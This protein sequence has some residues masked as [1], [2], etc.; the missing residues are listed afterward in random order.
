M[1]TTS[2]IFLNRIK[3]ELANLENDPPPGITC[4]PID[5][6]ITHLECYLQGP[7]QTPYENGIF[8]LDIKMPNNYPFDPPQIRFITPIYHP[9]I[10]EGGRICASILKKTDDG[11]K[12]SMN[13]ST[14]LISLHNLISSPNPDDP[15]DAEIANEYKMDYN[16][17]LRKAKDH[18]LKYAIEDSQNKT[19]SS[20]ELSINM[21]STSTTTSNN[22]CLDNER[23]LNQFSSHNKKSTNVIDNDLPFSTAVQNNKKAKLSLSRNKSNSQQT[24]S[25]PSSSQDSLINK[26][27]LLSTKK[28]KTFITPPTAFNENE[29]NAIPSSQENRSLTSTTCTNNNGSENKVLDPSSNKTNTDTE[30]FPTNQTINHAIGNDIT[31]NNNNNNNNNSTNSSPLS[32]SFSQEKNEISA[33]PLSS[34]NDQYK[35]ELDD[36]INTSIKRKKTGKISL[37][38]KKLKNIH[39]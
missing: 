30:F 6:D 11:W 31:N 21:K 26:K 32:S 16:I 3:K 10:D 35:N 19:T 12:P 28:G 20:P 8:Q 9:N 24:S 23:N 33:I 2:R 17:F 25:S 1:T 14:T 18:T 7:T 34:T 39:P 4:Y 22:D 29:G 15:L 37:S 27:S 5:D 36:N 13:L 38:C